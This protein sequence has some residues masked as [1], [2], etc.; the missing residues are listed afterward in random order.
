[1]I[2]EPQHTD[3]HTV[4]QSRV[5]YARVLIVV[6]LSQPM[7]KVV[8]IKR[9][10]GSVLE[11]EVIYEWYPRYCQKCQ[12]IGHDC[13]GQPQHNRP[14]NKIPVQKRQEKNAQAT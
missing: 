10:N 5:A 7:P 4:T 9:K 13:N 2:G 12:E 6:D 3:E 1:M 8:K 11:Q 14:E